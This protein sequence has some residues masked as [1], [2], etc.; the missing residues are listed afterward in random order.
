MCG[1]AA[2]IGS[3][4]LDRTPY[5][6]KFWEPTLTALFTRQKYITAAQDFRGCFNSTGEFSFWRFASRDGYDSIEY[7]STL[8]FSNG[9][10]LAFGISGMIATGSGQVLTLTC[11]SGWDWSNVSGAAPPYACEPPWPSA[12]GALRRR[13]QELFPQWRL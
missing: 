12:Y 9:K 10:I 2:D 13:I 4:I 1:A 6:A 8:P 11:G 7:L 3:I 5:G